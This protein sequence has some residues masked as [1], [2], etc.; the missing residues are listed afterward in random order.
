MYRNAEETLENIFNCINLLVNERDLHNTLRI[1]TNLGTTLVDS[2]RAS[3]WYWDKAK[4]QY[5]T[6]ASS[7]T[8]RIIVDEG[9]GIVGASIVNRE[10]IIINNPYEDDRFNP[11]VDKKTGYVT[12]SILC[13]P[14]YNE[15]GEAIGAYQAINKIGDC[16]FDEDDVSRLTLATVYSGKTLENYILQNVSKVDQLTGLK[17][18]RAFSGIYAKAY[19]DERHPCLMM[20][21]IDFFKKVNDTYGHNT[22]D[23]VLMH[24]AAILKNYVGDMGEVV[25]W[26]GEEFITCLKDCSLDEAVELAEL[27]RSR[28]QESTCEYDGNTVKI[29]MSFGVAVMEEPRSLEENVKDADEKLYAAKTGGRNRV[30]Y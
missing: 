7:G 18:R 10:N 25:R 27:I 6:L 4:K 11:E 19:D 12:K 21:D 28:V 1:L 16:G 8:D 2:D 26:G 5:W 29:T 24:V 13:M 3:F 14:V 20:C 15:Q 30:V 9:T 22:G 23:A 17:N